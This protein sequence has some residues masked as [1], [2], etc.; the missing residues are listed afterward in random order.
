MGE[1]ENL[2]QQDQEI[3]E[4]FLLDRMSDSE[5][6][7]F[8]VRLDSEPEFKRLFE[9][10]KV[11]FRAI[12]ESG[13]RSKLNEYHAGIDN[14]DSK[15][16]KIH[17]LKYKYRYFIAASV[18]FLIFLAGYKFMVRPNSYNNIYD[19]YYTVDPGLPTVMG[20]T[21]NYEFYKA[22]VD[23]KRGEY[24]TA[25]AKWEVLLVK[26]PDN[27]TLNYFLGSAYLA[28]YN[29]DKAIPFLERVTKDPR[30]FFYS[31]SQF[32]LGLI[33]VKKKDIQEAK[34]HLKLSKSEK[35]NQVLLQLEN[36]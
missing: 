31:D 6:A 28:K 29:M 14:D 12:E 26:K 9:E 2:S 33:F 18:A 7:T 15:I 25:I 3:F 27:D 13:L 32:F 10:F 21:G 36:K 16:R 11:M 8:Q 17:P 23:Y 4:Q 1:S 34:A 35:S 5:E 22:M 30:S 19:K 20:E 24:D